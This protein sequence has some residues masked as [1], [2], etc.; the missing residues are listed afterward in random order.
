MVSRLRHN[1]LAAG[2]GPRR[3]DSVRAGHAWQE[4]DLKHFQTLLRLPTSGRFAVSQSGFYWRAKF[5][6]RRRIV[7]GASSTHSF[8]VRTCQME[9]L[10]E[11]HR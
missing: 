9:R 6:Q 10:L 2:A 7:E 11:A 3:L 5:C 1:K 8:V 4:K